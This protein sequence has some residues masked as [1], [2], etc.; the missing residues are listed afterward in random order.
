MKAI[1]HQCDMCAAVVSDDVIQSRIANNLDYN[2]PICHEYGE[3]I[4]KVDKKALTQV[5]S[6]LTNIK[7]RE[8]KVDAVFVDYNGVSNPRIVVRFADHYFN[9]W[10]SLKLPRGFKLEVA[11]PDG[12]FPRPVELVYKLDFNTTPD[13][14]QLYAEIDFVIND[15]LEWIKR[16]PE[17]RS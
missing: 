2:C 5:Y 14:K 17:L 6:A 12:Q 10:R 7:D 1:M 16:F 3:E 4:L 15:L 11:R 9:D 13:S 8:F